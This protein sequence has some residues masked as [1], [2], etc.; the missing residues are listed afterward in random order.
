MTNL[1]SENT[2][3]VSQQDSC[4]ISEIDLST[5]VGSVDNTNLEF[6]TVSWD[7][8][9]LILKSPPVG[10]KEGSYICAGRFDN[11]YRNSKNMQYPHDFFI[12]DGDSTLINNK[13]VKGAPDPALVHKA[14]KEL[15]LQHIIFSTHSNKSVND[16][17]HRYRVLIPVQ[18]ASKDELEA[19]INW[20]IAKLHNSGAMLEDATEN[21]T[22]GIPWFLPRVTKDNKD[23]YYFTEHSIDCT[24]FPVEEAISQ[25]VSIPKKLVHLSSS[26]DAF[27]NGNRNN[28]SFNK[29]CDLFRE[30]KGHEQVLQEITNFN[31]KQQEPIETLCELEKLVNSASK[32]IYIIKQKFPLTEIGVAERFMCKYGHRIRYATSIECWFMFDGYRWI[33]IAK[34]MEKM[35]NVVRLLT[36]EADTESEID[37]KMKILE[38]SQRS[39]TSRFL[40]SVISIVSSYKRMKIKP[41]L[42]NQDKYLIGVGNGVVDLQ[43]TTMIEPDKDQYISKSTG[44]NYV[45]NASTTE[46]NDYVLNLMGGNHHM[47][48]YIQQLFGSCFIAGNDG[49]ILPIFYGSGRNGKTTLIEII[50]G[51]FGS[52]LEV[53]PIETFLDKAFQK[54][55]GD[56]HPE[57]MALQGARLV[58]AS[59]SRDGDSLNEALVKRLTGGDKLSARGLREKNMTTFRPQFTPILS[60]NHLPQ[61]KGD[62]SAIWE[63]LLPIPFNNRFVGKDKIENIREV[64]ETPEARESVLKW[65][66]NGAS[67]YIHNRADIPTV[68]M[69]SRN[70]YKGL[71]NLIDDWIDDCCTIGSNYTEK[72]ANIYPS[73]IKWCARNNYRPIGK[74]SFSQ[75]LSRRFKS[76]KVGGQSIRQ[77]F[78]LD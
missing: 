57:I 11:D 31:Q 5:S 59:E 27:Y 63:R 6:K 3:K 34:P 43:T 78:K 44:V 67:D 72:A 68:V 52:Y 24:A 7:K 12:L 77:G 56:P 62:S 23:C 65:A 50:S 32:Q 2:V 18:I 26:N 25:F 40:N 17:Y 53:T 1:N 21:M 66:L 51:V 39:E 46:I 22:Q 30:G 47:T 55:A 75:R 29:A 60:T 35:I 74:D 54:G 28:Y 19:C 16:K 4:I 13:P 33:T 36:L 37:K 9:C 38:F 69:D 41:E 64:F 42:F 45:A 10:E 73:Y 58:T 76:D 8:L 48:R 15:N 71:S 49:H 14:L 70:T 20:V 61:I